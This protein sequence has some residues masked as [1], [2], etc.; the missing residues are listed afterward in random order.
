MSQYNCIELKR[1]ELIE[2]IT[3]FGLSS[4][5]ALEKSEELDELIIQYQALDGR[6]KK[7][8]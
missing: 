8:G 3:M 4:N 5:I 6:A 7:L 1:K 2:V